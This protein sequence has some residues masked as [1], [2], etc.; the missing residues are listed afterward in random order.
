MTQNCLPLCGMHAAGEIFSVG[1]KFP[2]MSLYFTILA[3]P[4]LT[5]SC[6]SALNAAQAACDCADLWGPC[7]MAVSICVLDHCGPQSA[8][9]PVVA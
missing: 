7:F 4:C 6:A 2:L 5:L 8:G 9:H 3:N 1:G